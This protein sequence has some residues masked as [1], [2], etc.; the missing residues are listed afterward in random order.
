MKNSHLTALAIRGLARS[1]SSAP[2]SKN[3]TVLPRIGGLRAGARAFHF[4]PLMK[5]SF[6]SALASVLVAFIAATASA[7]VAPAGLT[8]IQS[9]AGVYYALYS[10]SVL[11]NR[12]RFYYLNYG[13]H[14]YDIINPTV[15]ASGT[16]SGTSSSTG[17]TVTGEIQSTSI[18]LT[19]NSATQSGP[20]ESLYGPTGHY[21]GQWRGTVSDPTAGI[22]FGEF[23]V[24]SHNECLVFFRQGFQSNVGIGTINP[25]GIASVPL[26]SGV[27]ISGTFA[28]ANG[29]ADGTFSLSIG[30][31]NTYSVTKAVTSRLANISTR[32]LVGAG[33]QG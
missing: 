27:T 10:D 32:G 1:V 12:C 23:I 3:A 6:V 29:G 13:T 16:F 30:G 26:L 25:N 14:E 5:T 19:Y 28:P 18:S 24:S 22:G 8:V 33:D 21:A 2:S 7:Q 15:S 20:K 17:R 9:P 31:Q 4:A 11:P